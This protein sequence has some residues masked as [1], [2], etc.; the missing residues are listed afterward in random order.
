MSGGFPYLF[1]N[2]GTLDGRTSRAARITAPDGAP[3]S[4]PVVQRSGDTLLYIGP[5]PSG[6]HYFQ[7]STRFFPG[8]GQQ[9][10]L[11]RHLADGSPDPAFNPI[12]FPSGFFVSARTGPTVMGQDRSMFVLTRESGAALPIGPSI[13]ARILRKYGNDGVPVPGYKPEIYTRPATGSSVIVA[14][15]AILLPSPMAA[16]SRSPGERCQPTGSART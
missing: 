9:I 12:S 10:R 5:G 15:E 8:S 13:Y 11:V 4:G 14:D 1:N 6:S 7:E 16:C 3:L 2:Q